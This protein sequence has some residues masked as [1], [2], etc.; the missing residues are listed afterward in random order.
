MASW[1]GMRMPNQRATGKFIDDLH[2]NST[3]NEKLNL[4]SRNDPRQQQWLAERRFEEDHVHALA[5]KHAELELLQW[6]TREALNHSEDYIAVLEAHISDLQNANGISNSSLSGGWY[7]NRGASPPPAPHSSK[8]RNV[9][10]GESHEV[11]GH[12]TNDYPTSMGVERGGQSHLSQGHG[13]QSPGEPEAH[14]P[15]SEEDER[16]PGGE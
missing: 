5:E 12:A 2:R 15:P 8:E 9:F 7:D 6:S 3:L 13:S 1:G 16:V 11:A 10:P 4:P 14:P